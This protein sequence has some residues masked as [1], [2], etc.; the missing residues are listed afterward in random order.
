MIQQFHQDGF[1]DFLARNAVEERK[2]QKTRLAGA[3]RAGAEKY[4]T[5]IISAGAV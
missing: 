4:S 2:K 5:D 3:K 1:Q